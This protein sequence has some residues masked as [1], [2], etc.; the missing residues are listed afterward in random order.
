[1]SEIKI[2]EKEIVPEVTPGELMLLKTI[3]DSNESFFN[4]LVLVYE[5]NINASLLNLERKMYLK[6]T[7][8]D[9]ESIVLRDKALELL[10]V[11][12]VT[13]SA[14]EVIKY[15][16]TKTGKNYKEDA[17]SSLKFIIAR[18]KEGYEVIDLTKVI[19]TMYSKWKGTDMQMYLRPETLFNATKFQSY[20]NIDEGVS[21]M[22]TTTMI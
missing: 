6:I 13:T 10:D 19:D 3:F 5:N 4:K 17:K 21:T 11:Q 14:R 22:S 1:M 2:D 12:K 16:N 7:G 20:L 18:L 9:F 15:L 8:E